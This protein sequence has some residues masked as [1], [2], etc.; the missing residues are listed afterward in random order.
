VKIA[1][2]GIVIR[3]YH[4]KNVDRGEDF[5]VPRKNFVRRPP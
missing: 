2:D 5:K 3:G 1:L 4:S